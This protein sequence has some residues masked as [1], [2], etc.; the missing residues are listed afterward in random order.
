MIFRRSFIATLLIGCVLLAVLGSAHSSSPQAANFAATHHA[1]CMQLAQVP[2]PE[3]CVMRTVQLAS[4]LHGI[5]FADQVA[6]ALL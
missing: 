1:R 4:V 6:Q 2:A 5:E 3:V